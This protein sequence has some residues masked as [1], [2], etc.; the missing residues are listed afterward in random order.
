MG[1]FNDM[2][3][4]AKLVKNAQLFY[5]GFLLELLHTNKLQC[6]E[7]YDYIAKCFTF[8]KDVSSNRELISSYSIKPGQVIESKQF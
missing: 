2:I 7:Y 4:F 3:K 1:F 6:S 8:L 5:E